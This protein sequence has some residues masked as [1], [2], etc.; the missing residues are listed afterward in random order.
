MDIKEMY[1]SGM[2]LR[3]IGKEVGLSHEWVRQLLIRQGVAMRNQ[4]YPPEEREEK[5]KELGRL[6]YWEHR[7]KKL[8]Y[9]KK[10]YKNHKAKMMRYMRRYYWE[11]R[12]AILEYQKQY[13]K[14]RT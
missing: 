12:P 5:Y 10:Y 14:N 1:E 7:E 8:E 11:H 6:Y 3:A 4:K 13:R 9:S 2:T